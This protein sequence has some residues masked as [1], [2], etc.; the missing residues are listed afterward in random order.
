MLQELK[1][2]LR[3]KNVFFAALPILIVLQMVLSPDGPPTG[4]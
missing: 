4:L 2:L 3:V 1:E